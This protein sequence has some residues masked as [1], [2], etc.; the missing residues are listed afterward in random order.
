MFIYLVHHADAV[1]PDVD[2]QRPLSAAGRAHAERLAA[3]AAARGVKP[4]AIW[5]S[6]K[7]RARQTAEPFWRACNPLAE[8]AARRGLQPTDPPSWTR[9]LVE[10]ETRDLMVVG[11]MP[12]LAR[13]LRL[14]VAGQEDAPIEFPAHGIV[15][16]E[17]TGEGW[18]E[19]WRLPLQERGMRNEE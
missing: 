1:G 2:P 8:F 18:V 3:K 15:A 10:G 9:D 17:S 12:N 19:R 5:H 11:H 4:A 14:L 6:G 13:T 7:L 16:L